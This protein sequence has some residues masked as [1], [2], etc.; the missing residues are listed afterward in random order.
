MEEALG[1]EHEQVIRRL[2]LQLQSLSNQLAEKC[3]MVSYMD[4]LIMERDEEIAGLRQALQV[5]SSPSVDADPNE[6]P[7]VE[8]EKEPESKTEA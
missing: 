4:A 2:Q 8:V 6:G 1:H 7:E 3:S 5:A